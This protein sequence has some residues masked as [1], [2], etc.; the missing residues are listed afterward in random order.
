MDLLIYRSISFAYDALP[1]FSMLSEGIRCLLFG[2]G[3]FELI[4]DESKAGAC[5]WISKRR[6]MVYWPT[7]EEEKKYLVYAT[8]SKMTVTKNRFPSIQT[9]EFFEKM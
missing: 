3:A 2:L 6:G 4:E 1:F 9:P 7:S 5:L 8:K